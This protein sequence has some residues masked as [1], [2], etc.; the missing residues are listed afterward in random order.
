MLQLAIVLQ[1]CVAMILDLNLS[2]NR[3]EKSGD[4]ALGEKQ[5]GISSEKSENTLNEKRAVLGTFYL[6]AA[7]VWALT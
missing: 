7:Y 5:R 4:A 1:L 3:K 2:K 6:V